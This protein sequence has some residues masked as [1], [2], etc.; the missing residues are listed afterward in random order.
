[1]K[2]TH[3][4]YFA[5]KVLNRIYSK[6]NLIWKHLSPRSFVHRRL[7]CRHISK[8]EFRALL[9]KSLGDFSN[10]DL[11][12]SLLRNDIQ[13]ILFCASKTLEHQ[14]DYLGS[15]WTKIDPIDW[16]RD[17]KSGFTWVERKFYRSYKLVDVNNDADIKCVW[18][19]NRC[20]HLLWLGESYMLLHDE[21]YAA[22]VVSQIINWIEN[23]PLMYS[24][25]WTC[26]MDVAF[27]AVNWMYALNMIIDS[28]CVTDTVIDQICKSLY[29][30]GF[31]I[32]NNLEKNIP[33]SGNHYLSDL[34]GLL[35]VAS[36]FPKN[37]Y[38][39]RWNE[40]AVYEFFN[41]VKKQIG[42]DGV[43]Y[44]NSLSYH[45][46]ISE[47]C[48]Y[49]YALLN[50]TCTS[51]PDEVSGR[52]VSLLDF[53]DCYIKPNGLSSVIGDNDDGRLLPFIKN[54]FRDHRYLL[55]VGEQLFNRKYVNANTNTAD[56]K[57]ITLETRCD[58]IHTVNQNGSLKLY[59][60]AKLAIARN[61]S[62]FII[63]TNSPFSLNRKMGDGRTKGTHTHSDLLSFE[64]NI[65]GQDIIVDAG[66]NV[67]TAN[68]IK[69]NQFRS[70]AMHNTIVID[71]QNQH[72][73]SD[74]NMFM[75]SSDTIKHEINGYICNN[76]STVVC[77]GSYTACRNNAQ[78]YHFR[79]FALS[80]ENLEI[81][82]TVECP[83]CHTVDIF[84]HFAAGL[85]VRR[86]AKGFAIKLQNN[87]EVS[88]ICS[89]GNEGNELIIDSSISPSY[90]CLEDSKI[91]NVKTTMKDKIKVITVIK[92][93]K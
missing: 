40:F 8:D 24:I 74:T 37:Q 85:D 2:Y 58:F 17:F 48:V 57:F 90:G 49:T 72:Q 79:N 83:G 34:V 20:H 6:K 75:M 21:R 92:W 78:M 44:E 68:P 56:A 31:Y 32:Y 5:D 65:G 76:G 4:Y 91:V 64:L 52:I 15:G 55:S 63:V 18:E 87:N 69:R 73:L 7:H 12:A 50:R 67:Y 62:S 13:T 28:D 26:S 39:Q 81:I 38:S 86:K 22:E 47:L 51:I 71:G 46:L 70:T 60:N 25:N 11:G 41:E 53:I 1:M 3:K 77:N 27:R 45:R 84:F 9:A 61:E 23:N 93:I 80:N 88:L 82:D 42:N 30:H 14:F 43:H 54:D 36:L 10:I 66:S 16:C 29:E 89:A 35:F 33:L 59:P 19:L